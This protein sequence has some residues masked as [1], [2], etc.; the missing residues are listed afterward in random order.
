MHKNPQIRALITLQDKDSVLIGLIRDIKKIPSEKQA[1]LARMD[2]RKE[3]LSLAKK[4]VQEVEISIKKLELDVETRRTSIARLK[5]RQFET[6]K[7]EEFKAIGDEISRYEAEVEELENCELEL[8]EELE[9]R[10]L[11]QTEAKEKLAALE[12][13]INEEIAELDSHCKE[14]TEEAKKRQAERPALL[15]PIDEGLIEQ[16][17]RLRKSKGLPVVVSMSEDGHCEGCHSK[18]VRSVELAIRE[19]EGVIYCEQCGRMV[20]YEI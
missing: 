6:K 2:K 8:M 4:A 17:E 16:Y 7:N 20:Y 12:A 9:T 1:M 3:R 10:R 5:T 18:F 11:T 15:K 19:G 13:T 14:L